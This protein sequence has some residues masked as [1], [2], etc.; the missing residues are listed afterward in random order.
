MIGYR[1]KEYLKLKRKYKKLLKKYEERE[2]DLKFL[3]EE[4][5]VLKSKIR[6]KKHE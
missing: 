2:E 6:G 5:Q 1:L 3:F 4:N